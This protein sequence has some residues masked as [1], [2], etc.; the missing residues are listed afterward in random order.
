MKRESTSTEDRLGFSL[1][2][3]VW[4]VHGTIESEKNSET[5]DPRMVHQTRF[6]SAQAKQR[7]DQSG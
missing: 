7:T 3:G 1:D 5:P 4:P 2:G 6:S